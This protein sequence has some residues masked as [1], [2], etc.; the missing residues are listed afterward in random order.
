MLRT[1][2][3]RCGGALGACVWHFV[4][5]VDST[6]WNGVRWVTLGDFGVT[7]LS[8]AALNAPVRGSVCGE[9]ASPA[10]S[11]GGKNPTSGKQPPLRAEPEPAPAVWTGGGERRWG[12]RKP[13]GL[14]S[15]PFFLLL[16]LLHFGPPLSRLAGGALQAALCPPGRD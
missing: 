13:S 1:A 4:D 5:F 14:S 16:L 10:G 12:W 2:V 8:A 11:E 6:V 15:A 7:L 9:A 3:G